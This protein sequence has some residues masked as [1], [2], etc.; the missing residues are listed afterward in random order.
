[1]KSDTEHGIDNLNKSVENLSEVMSPRVNAH[2]VQTR[3]ELD[4][5]GQEVITSSKVVLA[6][7]SEHGAE[8]ESALSNL[9]QEI[10]QSREQVDNRLH[11]IS[12]EV[13][14]S[15]QEWE[16]R[17]QSARARTGRGRHCGEVGSHVRKNEAE[18]SS[19]RKT[20]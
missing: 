10:N 15:I 14:S 18:G 17:V 16:S 9:R 4:K 2:I 11:A 19:Q 6:S 13:R 3:K 7:I 20:T 12:D 1:V 5:Q 8:N